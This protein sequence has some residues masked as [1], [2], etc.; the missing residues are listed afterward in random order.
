[1]NCREFE[2]LSGALLE[3]EAHTEAYVHLASC[4]HCR[5]VLDELGAIERAAHSLPVHEPDARLWDRIEAAAAAEGLLP[6]PADWRWFGLPETWLPARPAFAGALALML[7]L[8]AGLVSYPIMDLPVAAVAPAD[9]IAVAQ[10]ELVQEPSY[11]S[12]YRVHLNRVEERVLGESSPQ[13][14]ELRQLVAR[15]MAVVDQAI[16]QTASQLDEYPDDTLAR[17]EL[18]RLYQQKATV[19]QAMAESSWYRDGR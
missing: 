18:H 16:Q 7:L 5:L 3:G 14:A 9:P 17:E 6:Q 2:N 10:S 11:D 13:E 4:R 1:M 8:A 12:R 15:P 19:L